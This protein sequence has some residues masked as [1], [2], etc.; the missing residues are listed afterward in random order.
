MHQQ[1][2]GKYPEFERGYLTLKDL[3]CP[4]DEEWQQAIGFLQEY[5]QNP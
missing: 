5:Q 1:I 2:Q 4:Y 3:E